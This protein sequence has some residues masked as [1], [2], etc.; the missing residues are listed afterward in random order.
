MLGRREN[1]CF[2]VRYDVEFS[3]SFTYQQKK[4][5]KTVQTQNHA[6]LLTIFMSSRSELSL[7]LPLPLH[8]IDWKPF[9]VAKNVVPDC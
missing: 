3:V 6:A 8:S 5:N 1:G 4:T 2:V 7:S 9:V